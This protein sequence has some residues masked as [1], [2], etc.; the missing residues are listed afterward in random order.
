MQGSCP[1]SQSLRGEELP[2]L[3]PHG[4]DPGGDPAAAAKAIATGVRRPPLEDDAATASDG[5]DVE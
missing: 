2:L 3:P 4:G 1:P 5:P